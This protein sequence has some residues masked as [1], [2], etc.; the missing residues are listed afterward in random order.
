MFYLEFEGLSDWV[1]VKVHSWP[2]PIVI[3]ND[4]GLLTGKLVNVLAS[5]GHHTFASRLGFQFS[6]LRLR[7]PAQVAVEQVDKIAD[8]VEDNDKGKDYRSIVKESIEV[9]QVRSL[10]IGFNLLWRNRTT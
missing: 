9:W 8:R 7:P 2:V 4:R 5:T 3:F 1:F 6:W 10:L